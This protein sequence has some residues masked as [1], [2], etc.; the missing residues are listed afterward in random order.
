MAGPFKFDIKDIAR[1]T[2]GM[3]RSRETFEIRHPFTA[4]VIKVNEG[5]Q[6][7]MTG[8]NTHEDPDGETLIE[9]CHV[10]SRYK[11]GLTVSEFEDKLEPMF[12]A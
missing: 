4:D 10:Q 3:Y 5:D 12:K 7:V 1:G 6:F 2:L 8:I 9:F 11:V